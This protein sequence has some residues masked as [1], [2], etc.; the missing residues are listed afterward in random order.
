MESQPRELLYVYAL[1]N[2]VKYGDLPK[3]GTVLG[4]LLGEHPEYR[5]QAR[6]IRA[7]V[8]AVIAEV[9]ALTPE[10]RMQ[11]LQDLAPNLVD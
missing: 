5:A 1:Q 8:D 3:S 4:K 6:E 7:I 2:A 9:A 10:E 11:K